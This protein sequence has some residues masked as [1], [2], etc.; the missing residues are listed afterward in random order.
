MWQFRGDRSMHGLGLICNG[1]FHVQNLA[2]VH[3][4]RI[5]NADVLSFLEI[6]PGIQMLARLIAA[7][8][9]LI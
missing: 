1:F 5:I 4:G 7:L 9:E 2:L 8:I 6:L 3:I